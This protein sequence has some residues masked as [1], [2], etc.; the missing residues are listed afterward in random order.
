MDTKLKARQKAYQRA[1]QQVAPVCKC[2]MPM[3]FYACLSLICSLG[4]SLSSFLLPSFHPSFFPSFLLMEGREKRQP[5]LD[6][7]FRREGVQKSEK[8][9][10][11]IYSSLLIDNWC[12]ATSEWW[13]KPLNMERCFWKN[14]FLH[15]YIAPRCHEYRFTLINR[16]QMWERIQQTWKI[17]AFILRLLNLCISGRPACGE[18]G[19]GIISNNKGKLACL[20]RQTKAA[21]GIAQRRKTQQH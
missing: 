2:V 21:W 16:C 12:G 10:M 4:L 8:S 9:A 11:G 17:I 20:F 15:L 1:G 5:S 19:R 14:S 3:C 6:E 18:S 13:T 7:L